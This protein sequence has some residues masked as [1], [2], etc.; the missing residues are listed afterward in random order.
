MYN[1]SKIKKH[2]DDKPKMKAGYW[3]GEEYVPLREG[4]K[5]PKLGLDR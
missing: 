2:T 5:P 4:E 3:K 1:N